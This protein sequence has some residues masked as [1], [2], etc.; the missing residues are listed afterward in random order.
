MPLAALVGARLGRRCRT[1]S[2]RAAAGAI[3]VSGGLGGA[4]AAAEGG[5]RADRPAPDP[6]R[7][8]ARPGPLGADRDGARRAGRRRRSTAAGRS[9]LATPA[10]SIGLLA[11]TPI[12]TSD[13]AD[14]R[15]DAIDAGTAVILDS[16]VAAAAE[17]RPRAADRGPARRGAGEGADDRPRLR[18]AARTTRPN[19]PA[20]AAARELQEQLNRGATHAFSP[21]FGLAAVARPAGADT[22]RPGEE[23]GAVSADGPVSNL[24]IGARSDR[25]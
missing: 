20:S 14:Q 1:P 10:S 19:A 16:R 2:A 12:F 7:D 3:L 22:D 4:G 6:G 13:I 17:D 24:A 21:S 8:R 18:T 23:G 11:L 15:Q 9:P 25:S 5:G